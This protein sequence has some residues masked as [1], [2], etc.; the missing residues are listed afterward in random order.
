MKKRIR[1][2]KEKNKFIE[3]I[4]NHIINNKKE[5][6]IA[7]LLFFVGLIIGILFINNVN[8]NQFIEI[9]EYIKGLINKMK[10]VENIDNI[11]L[12]KESIISN[13][14]L[15]I[16]LWLASSTVIGIPVVYGTL[17]FRGFVLGYTISSIVATLGAGNGILFSLPSLLLHNIIFIPAILATA[18]SG[19]K[20]YKSI[21]KNREKE[22]VKIEFIRHTIFCAIMLLLLIISSFV[23]VYISTNL[24]KIVVNYIKI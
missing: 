5:Y 15:I 10:S 3:I 9:D 11:M 23:E 21:I 13:L 12:L 2:I 4:K 19:M 16:I 22:N 17:I 18:V 20:L 14:I 7:V 8:D 6:L 1:R 24:S